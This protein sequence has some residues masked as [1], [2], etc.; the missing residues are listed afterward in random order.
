ML[1]KRTSWVSIYFSLFHSDSLCHSTV[2]RDGAKH[3]TFVSNTQLSTLFLRFEELMLCFLGD[4]FP[5]GSY[6]EADSPHYST[7]T[8]HHLGDRARPRAAGQGKGTTQSTQ[9]H[10][11]L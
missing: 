3:E 9:A 5:V 2:V 10:V 8:W 7:Q 6:V 1:T 4:F 11:S